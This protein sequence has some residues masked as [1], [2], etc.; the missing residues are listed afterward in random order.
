MKR[1]SDDIRFRHV[2]GLFLCLKTYTYFEKVKMTFNDVNESRK[3]T[4]YC[5]TKGCAIL[6][7]TSKLHSYKN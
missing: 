3:Y 7:Y 2:E 5:I 1:Q 4:R 6:L